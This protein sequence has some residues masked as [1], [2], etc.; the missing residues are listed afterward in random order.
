MSAREEGLYRPISSSPI[1]RSAPPKG[2]L[3]KQHTRIRRVAAVA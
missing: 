1:L 2:F 3:G